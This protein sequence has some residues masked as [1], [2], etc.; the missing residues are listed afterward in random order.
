MDHGLSAGLAPIS[1]DQHSDSL[2][3]V[4]IRVQN[5]AKNSVK[6]GRS[7]RKSESSES[8]ESP[9]LAIPAIADIKCQYC[10]EVLDPDPFYRKIHQCEDK[11]KAELNPKYNCDICKKNHKKIFQGRTQ[12]EYDEHMALRHSR[13]GK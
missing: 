9:V 5:N 1:S 4:D 8:P 7:L 6:E 2:V 12:E 13:P 10:G 3:D 11:I